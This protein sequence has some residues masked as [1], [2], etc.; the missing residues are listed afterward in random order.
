M[1]NENR[2]VFDRL[3]ERYDLAVELPHP[4]RAH[5]PAEAAPA[6]EPSDQR[7]LISCLITFVVQ[8]IR[9]RRNRMALLELSD[10]QLKDV[11][12]SRCQAYGDYSRYRQSNSHD[13]ERK[14]R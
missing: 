2:A 8:K 4:L 3:S 14:C 13:L 6:A 9:A 10:E 5:L 7:H 11:G 1:R 12:L